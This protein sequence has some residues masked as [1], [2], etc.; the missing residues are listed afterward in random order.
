MSQGQEGGRVSTVWNVDVDTREWTGR[1]MLGNILGRNR[2]GASAFHIPPT[3]NFLSHI[4]TL[5]PHFAFSPQDKPLQPE[6]EGLISSQLTKTF[7]HFCYC[8]LAGLSQKPQ[9]TGKSEITGSRPGLTKPKLQ[10]TKYER[11]K[12][13]PNKNNPT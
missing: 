3:P 12:C 9:R 6:E 4:F 7:F 5:L 8:W 11:L 2:H 13:I 10:A 1:V